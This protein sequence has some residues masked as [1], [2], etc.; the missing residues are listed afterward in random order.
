MVLNFM[1]LT[2]INPVTGWFEII[3]LPMTSIQCTYK[4]KDIIEKIFDKTPAQ[5]S[6]LFNQQWLP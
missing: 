5:V 4:D 1:I 3:E 2:M 6:K